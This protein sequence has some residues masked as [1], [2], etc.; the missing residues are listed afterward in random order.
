MDNKDRPFV[1]IDAY[2]VH[3]IHSEKNYYK[4]CAK[5]RKKMKN[6]VCMRCSSEESKLYLTISIKIRDVTKEMYIDMLGDGKIF[7]NDCGCI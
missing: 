4:G 1:A 5:C 6:D 2:A 7:R 3:M